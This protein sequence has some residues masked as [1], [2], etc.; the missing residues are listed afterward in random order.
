LNHWKI[1]YSTYIN[2]SSRSTLFANTVQH[3]TKWDISFL[4]INLIVF[5]LGIC[6][7]FTKYEVEISFF[8]IIIGEVCLLYK[9]DQ[10]KQALVLNE[11][12]DP[13]ISQTP[14]NDLNHQ[15][16]R[17]LM[18]KQE[19]SNNHISKSHIKDCFDLVETQIDISQ[20]TGTSMQR[21]SSFSFGIFLGILGTFWKKLETTELVYVS[22]TLLAIGIF[23]AFII[24]L[25]PSKIEKLKEMKY[26]MQLYCRE[27]SL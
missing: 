2:K 26:F 17:Y 4:T 22:L 10:L 6:F 12:G 5:I 15:T 1:I 19:L 23:I 27:V 24:S 13:S 20:S 21:F 8:L 11:Y 7:Y 18:F 9:F 16:S 3:G 14:H 25:F